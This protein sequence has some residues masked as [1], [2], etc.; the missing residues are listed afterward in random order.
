MKNFKEKLTENLRDVDNSSEK[1][2]TTFKLHSK[3]NV[4]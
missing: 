2:T 3:K 1:E 4:I